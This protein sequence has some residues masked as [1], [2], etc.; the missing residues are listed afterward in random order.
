[1]VICLEQGA[2]LHMAQLMPLPLTVSCFSKIHIGFTFL[3]PA[4]LGSPGQ[5][6]LNE[7]VCVCVC[8]CVCLCLL[9]MRNLFVQVVLCH[10]SC[11][12]YVVCIIF[13]LFYLSSL[14][15]VKYWIRW[16]Q[17]SK[18]KCSLCACNVATYIGVVV[19]V[20]CFTVPHKHSDVASNDC[21]NVAV[22]RMCFSDSQ[23]LLLLKCA[24]CLLQMSKM[25]SSL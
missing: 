14:K 16:N 1:M 24:C 25:H 8:V 20:F 17:N 7:C 3:V 10:V 22:C 21:C 13:F 5:G 18:V 9:Y 2:V 11:I 4:H 23:Y 19:D 15:R 6:P 12:F